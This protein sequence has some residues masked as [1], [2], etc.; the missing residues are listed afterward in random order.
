MTEN[1]RQD[2][3]TEWRIFVLSFTTLSL[4]TKVLRR[5]LYRLLEEG[6]VFHVVDE[7]DE[8]PVVERA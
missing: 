6:L 3:G 8:P 7:R 5:W 1:N 4:S 2:Q